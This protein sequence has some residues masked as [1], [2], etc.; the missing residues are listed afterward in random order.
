MPKKYTPEVRVKAV[1][2]VFE[3]VRCVFLLCRCQLVAVVV[4]GER[5]GR[6]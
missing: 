5:G 4:G 2:Q 1:R 6:L 3:T